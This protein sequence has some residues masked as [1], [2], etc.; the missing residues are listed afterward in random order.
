MNLFRDD[1]DRL[2]IF[3]DYDDEIDYVESDCD[4]VTLTLTEEMEHV[5]SMTLA[6]YLEKEQSNKSES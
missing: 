6:A 1:S 3:L 4:G 2:C 5:I